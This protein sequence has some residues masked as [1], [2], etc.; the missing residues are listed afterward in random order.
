MVTLAIKSAITM[1]PKSK[2]AKPS[3][4][5]PPGSKAPVQQAPPPNWPALTP[6]LPS[7]S[8]SLETL[9]ADQILTISNLWTSTLCAKYVSFLRSLPLATTPGIP[10]KGDAVRVNDRFQLEDPVFAERLWSETGLKDV[11]LGTEDQKIWGGEV[12][13]LNPNI[14]I[15][16][17][18]KGQFFDQHCKFSQAVFNISIVLE[19]S[20]DRLHRRR[21]Q[22]HLL[23]LRILAQCRPCEDD[24]DFAA[25]SHLAGYRLQGRRDRL[26]PG[27]SK[28]ARSSATTSRGALGGRSGTAASAWE[29]LLAARRQGSDSGREVGDQKRSL[30]EAVGCEQ[31]RA[32]LVSNVRF[33]ISMR[34]RSVTPPITRALSPSTG[35]EPCLPFPT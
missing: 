17:Y 11:V 2:T 27:S 33:Y 26:L 21:L 19:V 23:P 34:M 5:Q 22:Q 10:K 20:A 12:L 9:L 24:L 25:V 35:R 15:Y 8:L 30:C 3:S 16:R 7:D 13:G 1:A 31:L 29:R 28:Q 4:K 32:R 18:S 6:I 14:R